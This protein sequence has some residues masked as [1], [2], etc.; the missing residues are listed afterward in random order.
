MTVR[1]AVDGAVAETLAALPTWQLYENVCASRQV[2]AV[3]DVYEARLDAEMEL[4]LAG[5]DADE[6]RARK[7]AV[8]ETAVAMGSTHGAA[9]RTLDLGSALELL[10][11]TALRFWC[12]VIDL[13]RVRS[14]CSTLG[15]AGPDTVAALEWQV[16]RH[17]ERLSPAAL[18]ARIWSLWMATAPDEA[19]AVRAANAR[20][21][22]R[23]DVRQEGD[24]TAKLVAR[25]SSLDGAEA[26]AVIT[27]M[28]ATVCA[29]DPR[30]AG[31]R[32]SAALMAFLRQEARVACRCGTSECHYAALEDPLAD[33]RRPLVQIVMDVQTLLG[34]TSSPARLA[35]G[36]VVDADIARIIATDAR[37]QGLL[38]EMAGLAE[39]Q[40][41]TGGGAESD[42][43]QEAD[44]P[45]QTDKPA[46]PDEPT[47]RTVLVGRTTD[48]GVVPTPAATPRPQSIPI[49]DQAAAQ[50]LRF[51]R[52]DPAALFCELAIGHGDHSQPPAG[53]LTYR[54]SARVAAAVRFVN[55]TCTFPGCSV[56]ASRCEL[57]HCVPF[58]HS[59]P[60]SGGWTV[61]ENLHPLC[62]VHHQLKTWGLWQAVLL[63]NGL[64][65]WRSSSGL[66][67]VTAPPRDSGVAPVASSA[68]RRPPPPTP[69][70]LGAPDETPIAEPTWWER[71]HPP[72][73]VGPT[74]ID[75]VR[76]DV[77]ARPRLAEI[78][79]RYH[80]HL[81][82]V[83]ARQWDR[84][85]PF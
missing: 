16:L 67:R 57:D 65:A 59:D 48:C 51:L 4:F 55:P 5:G 79:R 33:R 28:A 29:R 21:A 52:R 73:D 41:W 24:G 13:P 25:L 15:K 69:R 81:R 56:P 8:A 75:I 26:D 74:L 42:G 6:V 1:S 77:R 3:A 84:P 58:R 80:A 46:Q 49:V 39:S 35:D 44:A 40:G 18:T 54:P 2:G 17:A 32:R 53:A 43:D 70:L 30:S 78:R 82:T 64:V 12:G 83:R 63:G 85:C 72:G 66:L 71:H 68:S 45:A 14:I 60:Q 76:A 34:L 9:S 22:G 61:E 36:T 27:E 47:H 38:T 23:V 7:A 31:Q 10:P 11:G 37:W 50:W 19:A 62:T 20:T